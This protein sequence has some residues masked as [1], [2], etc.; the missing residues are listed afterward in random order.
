MSNACASLVDDGVIRG[1][2][3]TVDCQTK[4]YAEGGYLALTSGSG[5]F[6]AALTALLT[7][8]VAVIGLRLLLAQV[9]DHRLEGGPAGHQ[10][11]ASR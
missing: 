8:Y 5:V 3:A 6:Q 9:E 4:A 1:V 2:L 7:I 11:P 10:R